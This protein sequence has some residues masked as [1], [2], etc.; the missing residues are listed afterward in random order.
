MNAPVSRWP[1]QAPP[2][3]TVN[4]ESVAPERLRESLDELLARYREHLPPAEIEASLPAIREDALQN[5]IERTLLLQTA[6]KVLS[7]RELAEAVTEA[8]RHVEPM[9]GPAAADGSHDPLLLARLEED[10]VLRR[11]YTI[12][13]RDVPRPRMDEC[14]SFYAQHPEQF[15]A[16]EKVGLTIL[17]WD[18]PAAVSPAVLHAHLLNARERLVGGEPVDSVL[19][20]LQAAGAEVRNVRVDVAALPLGVVEALAVLEVGRWS[21]IVRWEFNPVLIRLDE[22][23]PPCCASFSE[24]WRMVED[25]LWTERKE[26]RIGEEVDRMLA[27]AVIAVQ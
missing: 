27:K 15:N 23:I 25:I 16:G 12:L 1:G 20:S 5:A 3:V 17:R 10:A 7:S 6:R 19:V 8:R 21:T 2:S 11:Y 18:D 22:R 9:L 26:A 4:G 13:C 24:V 14:R